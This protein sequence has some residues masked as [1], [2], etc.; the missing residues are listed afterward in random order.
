MITAREL[1]QL[2]SYDK[3]TGEF[4]W[5]TSPTAPVAKGSKAG[6]AGFKGYIYIQVCGRIY[7]AHRLA[8]LYVTG[9]WPSRIVDHKDRN[10]ANNSWGNLRQA[11]GSQNRQNA[12]ISKSNRSG[13]KGVYWSK[14][15]NKWAAQIKANGISKH[16]IYSSDKTEAAE[17][18]DAAARK[19]HGAFA[20]TNKSLGLL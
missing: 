12:G 9:K 19:F 11:T 16:L 4:S 10:P 7:K 17:A 2:L 13:F 14:S 3:E 20:V 6:Y 5:L 1:R 15:R 8:W 18:Y